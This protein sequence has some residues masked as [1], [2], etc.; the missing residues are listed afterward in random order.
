MTGELLVFLDRCERE[1]ASAR[2]ALARGD[3]DTA[4]EKFGDLAAMM[5][6]KA[7]E[8]RAAP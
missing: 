2:D 7:I 6:G 3:V 1:W 8:L 4:I 5:R